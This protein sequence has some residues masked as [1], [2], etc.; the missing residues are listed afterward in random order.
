LDELSKDI[1]QIQKDITSMKSFT[2]MCK[3]DAF[4]PF[5]SHEM[6]TD[7]LKSLANG[8]LSPF[9]TDFVETYFP[10]GKKNTFLAVQDN[11]LAVLFNTNMDIVCKNNDA[12]AELFRGIR[13]H[14]DVFLKQNEDT[15]GIELSKAC[16]G[17][18][19]AVS[20]LSIQ[21]DVNRQDK[22]IINSYCLIDQMEKNL[23]TFAMRVKEWYGW[24]FPELAKMC[25]DNEV[26]VR[27][28]NYIG[29]RDNMSDE[30]LQELETIA[31]SGELAQKVLEVCQISYGNE[32]TEV[33][34]VS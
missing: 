29:N 18:G 6:A 26:Y 1:T 12:I 30:N 34:E 19:H 17:L 22:G 2:K 4:K 31:Q 28:V 9:V 23:N 14:F 33:D 8:E 32:L 27:L 11:R 5:A 16:L 25:T 7:T 24:H 20:R 13:Y 21:F 3:L 10:I 15:D